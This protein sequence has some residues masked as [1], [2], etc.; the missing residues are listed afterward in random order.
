MS[1]YDLFNIFAYLN[2]RFFSLVQSQRKSNLTLEENWDEQ[3]VIL[4]PFAPK[5]TSLIIKDH[6]FINFSF[7]QNIN[8]LKICMPSFNQSNLISPSNLPNLQHLYISNLYNSNHTVQSCKL[9]FSSSFPNL[10]HYQIDPKTLN[11]LPS[12]S[13][14][15]LKQL[16]FPPHIWNLNIFSNIFNLYTNLH[17]LKIL[18][19]HN[20][21]SQL[22]PDSIPIEKSIKYLF[23]HSHSLEEQFY[24]KLRFIISNTPNLNIFILHLDEIET[25]IENL[26]ISLSQIII[27]YQP[28]LPHFIA[29]IS[30][31]NLPLLNSN[32][33]KK[34]HRLFY[35]IKFQHNNQLL[36][37]SKEL[38]VLQDYY[39]ANQP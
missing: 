16:T 20:V 2:F 33:I 21:N 31:K 35:R 28:N 39:I 22:L 15:S 4:P 11:N 32:Y 5:T 38:S 10:P 29:Q 17:Y 9:I 3:E 30:S 12:N 13:S 14:L 6:Q 37:L 19:L 8:S 18:N 24:N 34:L 23:I 27:Q 26:F 25:D 1:T 7:F 36:I